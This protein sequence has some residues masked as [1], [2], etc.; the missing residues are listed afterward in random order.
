M[1]SS[2]I[3]A[4]L[5]RRSLYRSSLLRKLLLFKIF[6]VKFLLLSKED[7]FEAVSGCLKKLVENLRVGDP[8]AAKVPATILFFLTFLVKIMA[9]S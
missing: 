2:V 8:F 5:Q 1:A 6:P 4:A 7:I 3:L 9:N